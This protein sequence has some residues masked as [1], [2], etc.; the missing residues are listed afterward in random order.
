VEELLAITDE[1][2]SIDQELDQL[3]K[4]ASGPARL[5]RLRPVR[6]PEGQA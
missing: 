6:I 4:G 3:A 5:A 1:L 2:Q